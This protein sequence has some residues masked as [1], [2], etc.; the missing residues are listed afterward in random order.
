MSKSGQENF[1]VLFLNCTLKY[2]PEKS[3]TQSLT[4]KVAKLYKEIWNVEIANF[5]ELRRLSKNNSG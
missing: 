5:F 3:H 1:K 4:D 2:S